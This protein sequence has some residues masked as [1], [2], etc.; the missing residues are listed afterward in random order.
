MAVCTSAR[1]IPPAL[2]SI[3][4]LERTST[5]VLCRRAPKKA[6]SVACA[7]INPATD[8]NRYSH[9]ECCCRAALERHCFGQ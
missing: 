8:I 7:R 3:K 9:S 6:T 1:R 5:R 2:I 4:H